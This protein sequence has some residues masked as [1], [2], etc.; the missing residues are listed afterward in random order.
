MRAS[1]V[2]F[3]T[4][5]S[6]R[7]PL[8]MLLLSGDVAFGMSDVEDEGNR[9]GE[10]WHFRCCGFCGRALSNAGQLRFVTNTSFFF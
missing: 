3:N 5:V 10:A 6:P 7:P 4:M 8:I 1:A 9:K 2:V